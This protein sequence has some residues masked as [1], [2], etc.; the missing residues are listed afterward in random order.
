MRAMR[1]AP[2]AVRGRE[3]WYPMMA[4]V[5]ANAYLQIGI[6]DVDFGPGATRLAAIVWS[7]AMLAAYG[8]V[9]NDSCDVESDRSAG[10]GNA[11][12]RFAMPVRIAL[13]V[14]LAVAGA[15]PWA[16]VELNRVAFVILAVIYVLPFVYSAPPL[17]WKERGALGL[18]ADAANA[19]LMP[20]LFT[21]AVYAGEE[22]G[23]VPVA[24]M[25]VATAVWSLA[26]GVRG[27]VAHQL[28]DADND[29]RSGTR[30]YVVA[31]SAP[32]ARLI[33]T[34]VVFPVELVGA[35]VLLVATATWCWPVVLIW[36]AYGLA[37]QLARRLKV[38]DVPWAAAPD[39][40]GYVTLMEW[41]EVWPGLLLGAALIAVDPLYV[42][43][44]VAHVSVF[45]RGIVKQGR[46]LVALLRGLAWQV[47]R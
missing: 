3:W 9:I 11:M 41:Y 6:R 47:R 4:P 37:F 14:A 12:A 18:L 31:A 10:K 5:A 19:H 44:L 23:T 20:A 39:D 30:T 8:H 15:V 13:I 7:G 22:E 38:W 1:S 17:R 34:R 26:F 43:V 36:A 32:R 28:A 27:I 21:V 46:D 40:D 42:I 25:A 16:F 33:V 35:V 29:Q 45:R 2:S 24:V